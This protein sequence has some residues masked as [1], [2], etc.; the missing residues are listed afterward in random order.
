ML[1]RDSQGRPEASPGPGKS[2]KSP[3]KHGQLDHHSC[4]TAGRG[5]GSGAADRARSDD[6]GRTFGSCSISL[7]FE[8]SST[9]RESAGG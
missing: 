7:S 1:R 5:R 8:V 4:L 9:R 2:P 3:A 6:R